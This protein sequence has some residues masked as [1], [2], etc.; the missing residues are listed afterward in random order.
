MLSNRI[1]KQTIA[2]GHE[3]PWPEP[4]GD[5]GYV[6]PKDYRMNAYPRTPEGNIWY[7]VPDDDYFSWLAD[8]LP[9]NLPRF[10]PEQQ[11]IADNLDHNR[12]LNGFWIGD[13]GGWYESEAASRLNYEFP[14]NFADT[15]DLT[16][17]MLQEG[18][19]TYDDYVDAN[20]DIIGDDERLLT[21]EEVIL[22]E[23]GWYL[24]LKEE[25]RQFSMYWPDFRKMDGFNVVFMSISAHDEP[26]DA[27]WRIYLGMVL[28]RIKDKA[29]RIKELEDFFHYWREMVAK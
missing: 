2:G 5:Q 28:R 9:N 8:Y 20:K 29:L 3:V 16:T 6:F 11:K 10:T 27:G 22:E 14:C 13:R 18:R 1:L 7:D 17:A 4:L 21:K 23:F 24:T 19:Y 25:N 15:G 12:R 26:P